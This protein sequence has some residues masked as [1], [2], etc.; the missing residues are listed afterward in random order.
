MDKKKKITIAVVAVIIAAAVAA[1]V[2]AIVRHQQV[3]A[4]NA[5]NT[6]VAMIN[7]LI[8]EEYTEN[9]NR[10]ELNEILQRRVS[11]GKYGDVED[12]FKNYMT[13]LYTIVYD[14]TDAANDD[15]FNTFLSPENM[16]ND[17]P[18]F[19]TSKETANELITRLET[20]K[21]NYEQMLTAEAID[22]YAQRA[23]LSGKY[24]EMYDEITSANKTTGEADESEF[25]S[26]I[27]TTIAQLAGINDV[28]DFLEENQ[29]NWYMQDGKL[30]FRTET[31]YNDYN[32]L[33]Q[34]LSA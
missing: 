33:I 30:T 25:T 18:A 2:F 17:G 31:L 29:N 23:G 1:A 7:D 10:D 22:S 32:S 6:E 11:S 19:E 16:E 13:E 26:S 15:A 12:A 28:F 9:I 27:D 21:E 4:R 5:V 20:D 3:S 8:N 34:E 14:A 24:K